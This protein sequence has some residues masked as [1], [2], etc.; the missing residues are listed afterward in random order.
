MRKLIV[1]ALCLFACS[2]PFTKKKDTGTSTAG[3][4]AKQGQ[5]QNTTKMGEEAPKPGDIKVLDGVE[6][7]Y[8]RNKRWM[9]TP[10]EPEYM[11]IRKDQ[12]SPAFGEN[13][14]TRG[15]SQEQKELE[16]RLAKIEEEM[17]KKG[18]APQMTYPS[19]MTYLP[20]RTGYLSPIPLSAFSYPSPKMKRRVVV[21]PFD[22][23]DKL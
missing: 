1:I 17:K 20:T 13:L 9:F 4:E 3:S 5:Q 22:R 18:L 14:L 15:K 21:L 23:P 7:I 10:Y 19:Q 12:Y 11:W 2:S 6:Y 8:A 16:G